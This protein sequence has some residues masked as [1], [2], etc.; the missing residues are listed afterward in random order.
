MEI[1]WHSSS[2]FHFFF[3]FFF[4]KKVA[5]LFLSAFWSMQLRGFKL[6][7]VAL[8]VNKTFHTDSSCTHAPDPEGNDW[9]G[10]V[11][12]CGD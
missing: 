7:L 8:A 9:N 3:F 1:T 4:F 5:D 11:C 6:T 2:Y 10:V 12:L